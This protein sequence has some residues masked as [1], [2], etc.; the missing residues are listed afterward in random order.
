MVN[1]DDAMLAINNSHLDWDGGVQE[2]AEHDDV[3]EHQKVLKGNEAKTVL[4][5]ELVDGLVGVEGVTANVGEEVNNVLHL[6]HFRICWQCHIESSVRIFNVFS[7][8]ALNSNPLRKTVD[9]DDCLSLLT[10]G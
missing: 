5:A 2:V 9:A 10:T 7:C 8:N 3:L 4:L 1:G 6:G